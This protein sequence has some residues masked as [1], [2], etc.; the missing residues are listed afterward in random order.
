MNPLSILKWAWDNSSE[1]DDLYDELT[2]LPAVP[3]FEPFVDAAYPPMKRIA[4]IADTFPVEALKLSAPAPAPATTHGDEWDWMYARNSQGDL[5][6]DPQPSGPAKPRLSAI[7]GE[8]SLAV[9]HANSLG[10][11]D[12]G[13]AHELAVYMIGGVPGDET[14]KLELRQATDG[15][16]AIGDG[17]LFDKVQK[18]IPI[19]IQLWQMYQQFKPL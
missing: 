8:Y 11:Y 7:G 19:I 17:K 14:Y 6:H 12:P 5:L 1:A 10:I 18:M 4:R 2:T 13:A 9:S 16:K 15:L 3:P